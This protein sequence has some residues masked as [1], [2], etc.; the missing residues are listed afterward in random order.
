MTTIV[1]KTMASRDF[2]YPAGAS[3][4]LCLDANDS[5]ECLNALGAYRRTYLSLD[6]LGGLVAKLLGGKRLNLL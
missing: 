6:C 3:L 2:R 5:A 4:V 1:A